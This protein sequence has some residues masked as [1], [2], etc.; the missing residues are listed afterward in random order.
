MILK[1]EMIGCLC[2]I[3]FSMFHLF[4]YLLTLAFDIFQPNSSITASRLCDPRVSAHL[5]FLLWTGSKL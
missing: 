4:T 1:T 3:F 5:H 2:L